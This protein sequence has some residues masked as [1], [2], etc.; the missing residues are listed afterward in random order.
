MRKVK[1][2]AFVL[3]ALMVVAAFAGCGTKQLKTDVST[4][5]E[6]VTAL[7]TLLKQVSETVNGGATK[8]DITEILDAITANKAEAAAGDKTLADAIAKITADQA[9]ANAALKADLE[10]LV[11]A[12]K[13]DQAAGDTALQVA[14][15]KLNNSIDATNKALEDAIKELEKD[16]AD[17]DKATLDAVKDLLD[18]QSKDIADA[19]EDLKETIDKNKEDAGVNATVQGKA[20]AYVSNLTTAKTTYDLEEEHYTASDFA[21]IEKAITN[22]IIA[23]QTATTVEAVDAAYAAVVA[24][25]AKYE[26]VDVALYNAYKAIMGKIN[27]DS[28]DA[29]KAYGTQLSA[30]KTHYKADLSVIKEYVYAAGKTVDLDAVAKSFTNAYNYL[31]DFLVDDI[32]DV[33]AQISAIKRVQYYDLAK[34]QV[35]NTGNNPIVSNVDDVVAAKADFDAVKKEITD[36]NKTYAKYLDDALVD[37]VTNKDALTGYVNTLNALTK[38]I[39]LFDTYGS[40]DNVG[41]ING[42]FAEYV[43]SATKDWYNQ[44]SNFSKVNARIDAWLAD[45]PAVDAK[46]AEA[47]I[48]EKLGNISFYKGYRDAETRSQLFADKYDVFVSELLPRIKS[49]CKFTEVSTE[50][51]QTYVELSKDIK[52]WLI[53][54]PDGSDADKN[55]DL[56]IE[57]YD[58]L[59]SQYMSML[60]KAFNNN[61]R[62][63]TFVFEEKEY[64]EPFFKNTVAKA[65]TVAEFINEQ[66]KVLAASETT[67]SL[68]EHKRLE[69]YVSDVNGI[70]SIP[71]DAEDTKVEDLIDANDVVTPTVTIAEFKGAFADSEMNAE[72]VYSYDLSYLLDLDVLEEAEEAVEARVAAVKDLTD[73]IVENL[74]GIKTALAT[75]A[76]KKLSDYNSQEAIEALLA[77]ATLQNEDAVNGLKTDYTNLIA[78]GFK[79]DSTRLWAPY[80]DANG[81]VQAGKYVNDPILSTTTIH[82]ITG[83]IANVGALRTFA[84]NLVKFMKLVNDANTFEAFNIEKIDDNYAYTAKSSSTI[85]SAEDN[86]NLTVYSWK[87]IL[88]SN[89]LNSS[90]TGFTYQSTP[91]GTAKY[92]PATELSNATNSGKKPDGKISNGYKQIAAIEEAWKGYYAFLA[93]NGGYTDA[94]VEQGIVDNKMDT[95]LLYA[96]KNIAWEAAGKIGEP[97]NWKDSFGDFATQKSIARNAIKSASSIEAISDILHGFYE[98]TGTAYAQTEFAGV[99]YFHTDGT[100]HVETEKVPCPHIECQH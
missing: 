37:L 70:Y 12:A 59:G 90:A 30:A 26:R 38:A 2:L 80:K 32:D 41:G 18:D 4:L 35:N 61:K 36:N 20:S 64:V 34:K 45:N 82:E 24:E 77:T 99:L 65:E 27:L 39:A 28:K 29:I 67:L 73:D 48:N 86:K 87:Y 44:G 58:E 15:E 100:L 97:D 40:F 66:I 47:I 46:N 51:V 93:A 88:N 55:P 16:I 91:T 1:V 74:T 95:Y 21:A 14:I 60:Q 17:G 84:N 71:A 52:E 56:V 49:A 11:D 72:V 85:W 98:M 62:T 68:E 7:E 94:K 43:A 22:G 25:L 79:Q 76:K 13:K 10:K 31:T 81:K 9:T 5:D 57:A 78:K 33:V 53:V 69:G 42:V 3:A 75:A 19:L 6:R 89:K 54:I 50:N 8:D 63:T 92:D 23:I 96:I 83:V